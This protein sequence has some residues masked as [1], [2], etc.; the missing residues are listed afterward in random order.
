MRD[1]FFEKDKGDQPSK[2]R[3]RGWDGASEEIRV[4]FVELAIPK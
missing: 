4:S 3:K 1:G 2:S